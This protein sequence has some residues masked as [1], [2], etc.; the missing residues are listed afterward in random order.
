M[1]LDEWFNLKRNFI[2]SIGLRLYY[3]PKAWIASGRF[4]FRSYLLMDRKTVFA[5]IGNGSESEAGLS[6]AEILGIGYNT[7]GCMCCKLLKVS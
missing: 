7:S 5:F 4:F 2:L 3:L 6:A 1:R